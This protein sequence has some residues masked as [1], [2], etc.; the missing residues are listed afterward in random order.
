[1][2]STDNLVDYANYQTVAPPTG[3][4]R[5]PSADATASSYHRKT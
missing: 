3:D 4:S 2:S 5:P 1:M